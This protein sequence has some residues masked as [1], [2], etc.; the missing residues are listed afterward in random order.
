MGS[1]TEKAVVMGFLVRKGA[2][3]EDYEIGCLS[4]STAKR[5]S[6]GYS[7]FMCTV[8]R[9]FDLD[10]LNVRKRATKENQSVLIKGKN[11]KFE[12]S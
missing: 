4:F 10:E 5:A 6:I 3:S 11:L 2:S 8:P 1:T 7:T 9:C 12:G